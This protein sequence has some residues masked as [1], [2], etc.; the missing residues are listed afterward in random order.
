MSIP[1]AL[2]ATAYEVC[3]YSTKPGKLDTDDIASKSSARE[4]D[5][6]KQEVR[7]CH[8]SSWEWRQMKNER[9]I[10]PNLP[11]L[12][13]SSKGRGKIGRR[14]VALKNAKRG[15]TPSSGSPHQN[16]AFSHASVYRLAINSTFLLDFLGECTD[17][18]FPEDRNV[19]LRP[20]KYLV[21]Y[22]MEIRQ[23]FKDAEATLSLAVTGS[24]LSDQA[25]NTDYHGTVSGPSTSPVQGTEK[26]NAHTVEHMPHA[27]T[28]DPSSAKAKRDQIRC[29]IDFMDSDM[30]DIFEVKHQVSSQTLEEVSFEHLWLLYRPG[31]LVYTIRSLEDRATYQAF[32]ILHVTGGRPILDTSNHSRFNPLHHRE[33]DGDSET[34]ERLW[35]AIRSSPL[36]MTPFIIDCFSI[37]FDGSKLGPKSR[38]FAIPTFTGKRK[39]DALEVRPSFSFAQHERLYQEMVERGR[40][41]TQI[42]DSTHKK[43]SG[44]TLRESRELIHSARFNHIIHDEEVLYPSTTSF[45]LALLTFC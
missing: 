7:I 10:N 16:E 21:A 24:G 12:I 17:M 29:L 28:I 5:L 2:N 18:D 13:A 42:A 35:D 11:I 23:A 45:L 6:Q 14:S 37:D 19:W 41:F 32:R 40:R 26:V 3:H 1:L 27:S 34:E 38:R 25:D 44:A 9:A 20:F 31:D 8:V 39:M 33:F 4:R 30:H 15:Q 43:Y 22:E 36:E